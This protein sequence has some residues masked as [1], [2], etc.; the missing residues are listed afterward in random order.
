MDNTQADIAL[1]GLAVMGQ[2]LILNMNDHGFTVVAFNRTVEK[3]DEFMAKEAKGTKVIGAHSIEEMVSKL[4]KPRRVMLMVK[5]GKP[6][7]EFI[8]HLLPDILEKGD[9]IID[10]GNSLFDD[11]NLCT[12]YVESKEPALRHCQEFPAAKKAR[13]T[14]RVSCPVARP[15]RGHT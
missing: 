8:E 6:V 11:T 5:A 3:V 12:K 1:I 10:G 13:V 7:D 4:K 15:P 2:N 14:A 9:I